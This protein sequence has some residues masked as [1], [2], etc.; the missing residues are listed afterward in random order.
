MDPGTTKRLANEFIDVEAALAHVYPEVRTRYCDQ[1]LLVYALGVGAGGDERDLRFVFEKHPEFAA[2]PTFV[3]AP[4]LSVALANEFK[5]ERSPGLNYGFDRI[6]HAVQSTELRKPL[7]RAAT[8]RHQAKVKAVYDSRKYAIVVT[9]VRT[10]DEAGEELAV[11]EFTLTVRGA[12]SFGGEPAPSGDVNVPPSRPPDAVIEQQTREDQALLYRLTGDRNPLHVDP[13]FAHDFGLPKPILH[14]LCTYGFAAR[15]VLRAM[16]GDDARNF[17][18]IRVKFAS[19]VFPGETLVTEMWQ[20]A[21]ARIVFQTTAKERG[22]VVLS[23]A[24]V[25]LFNPVVRPAAA[26][27]KPARPEA[28][29]AAAVQRLA[30][31]EGLVARVGAVVQLRVQE[32]ASDWVLDLKAGAGAVRPGIAADAD[33]TLHMSD[34]DLA[35]WMAGTSLKELVTAGRIRLVSGDG[36]VIQRASAALGR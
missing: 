2:L 31:D 19:P 14:G 1:D 23:N 8:L 30:V 21:P 12:G 24:A 25:E 7:P 32:P 3:V 28:P 11:N 10:C 5:G 33:L 16:A 4:A 26:E 18:S 34:A 17:K 20:E 6:L 35:A 29:G 22:K 13:V 9:Q 15:H 36:R 27:P